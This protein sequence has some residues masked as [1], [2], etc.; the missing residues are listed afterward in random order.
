MPFERMS[1]VKAIIRRMAEHAAPSSPGTAAVRNRL[2][3]AGE[4]C[5]P[6][7]FVCALPEVDSGLPA[8]EF[9]QRRARQG[10]LHYGTQGLVFD[11][12]QQVVRQFGRNLFE[13]IACA[14]CSRF[15]FRGLLH[16]K[17]G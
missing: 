13:A 17:P 5:Q 9:A 8:I 11:G 2:L 10:L 7:A 3:K 14:P 4:G 1:A 15:V 12:A 16:R 6:A